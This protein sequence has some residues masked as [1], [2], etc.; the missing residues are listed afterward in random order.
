MLWWVL[1]G[2]AC[3]VL[4]AGPFAPAAGQPGS[5]AVPAAAVPAGGWA[6]EVYAFT[7]GPVQLNDPEAG[8]ATYG[9]PED[10][11]GPANATAFNTTPVVSLGDGG[12]ITLRLAQPCGNRPG[13]D[14]A[15]FENSFNDDFL[16][17]AQVAVSTDGLHFVPFPSISLTPTTRQ[18]N[19]NSTAETPFGLL[20][21][22]NLYNLAGKYRAG[23][24]TP[25][26]L[27][28]LLGREGAEWLDFQN[29]RYVRVTD[30]VG[31][32][33]S[34]TPVRDSMNNIINDPWATPYETSGFD[35]DAVANLH[36]VPE[37]RA[38]WLLGL[39]ACCWRQR[40][41]R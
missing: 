32:I 36:P 38:A 35:L 5:T 21:P 16:E 19:G 23:F 17:L 31:W 6:S 11:L 4:W 40:R 3:P 7:R 26:E 8:A 39:A 12:S 28:E 13:F 2:G 24:G 22:T 25:F 14:L 27:D 18:V 20:D 30:V 15:V 37:P 34:P 41:R 29:I 33:H 9:E 10:A 1:A